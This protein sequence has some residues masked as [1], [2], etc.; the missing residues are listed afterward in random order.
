MQK[1]WMMRRYV[2]V[3]MSPIRKVW[4]KYSAIEANPMLVMFVLSMAFGN[5]CVIS[6]FKLTNTFQLKCLALCGVS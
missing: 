5:G 4:V 6:L 2:I 1:T 3:T